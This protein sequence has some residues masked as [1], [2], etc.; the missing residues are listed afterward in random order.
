MKISPTGA[1]LGADVWDVQLDRLDNTTFQDIYQAWLDNNGVLRFPCQ[2]LNDDNFLEFAARFG[3]LDLAPINANGGYWKPKYPELAVISNVVQ[4]GKPVGSLGSYES[5]WHTDMSYNE[6]PPKASILY[7]IELP[8]EGGDTG[9]ASTAAAYDAL[10]EEMK[11]RIAGLTCKH[12][13]SHNSVGQVRK[14]FQKTYQ[15]R[16]DTPGAVHPLVAEHPETGRKVIYLGRRAR[17]YICELEKFESDALL[18]DLFAH[19]TR[20]QFTWTQKWRL[21]DVVIWDNRCT[22]HR[23]DALDPNE[24]RLLHRAQIKDVG[25][26][27][28]VV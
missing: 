17:A 2:D 14:G 1:A 11:E 12:D 10:S 9:F 23:R 4:N 25:R 21:G 5:K 15:K 13:S 20:P 22:L 8:L 26:M 19:I 3:E 7:A 28:A 6:S 16:E 27:S 24:R 18:D